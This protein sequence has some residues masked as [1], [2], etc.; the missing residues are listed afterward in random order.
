MGDPLNTCSP[1]RWGGWERNS[2]IENFTVVCLDPRCHPQQP[3]GRCRAKRGVGKSYVIIIILLPSRYGI[4]S[5]IGV[6]K[7]RFTLS[8]STSSYSDLI[9]AQKKKTK[10][11]FSIANVADLAWSQCFCCFLVLKKIYADIL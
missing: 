9:I 4:A 8:S 1:R 11:F 7:S 6:D 3:A 10:S 5:F 2:F